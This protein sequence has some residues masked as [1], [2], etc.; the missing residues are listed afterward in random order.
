MSADTEGIAHTV[1]DSP[2]GPLT[3]VATDGVLSGLYMD[4]QRHAPD[5]AG[6]GE[7]RP[8]CLP[9]VSDELTAYFAGDLTTFTVP[10]APRGTAFQHRVWAALRDIRYGQTTTYGELAAMIG[11][12]TAA[13]AVGL[14]NGRN[15]IGIVIPCHRVL[16]FGGALTGYG[17]GLERKRALLAME[18]AALSRS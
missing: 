17:G 9:A 5:P 8:G 10:I 2:L 16:G 4:A 14:A 1:V 7:R 13:R 18:S 6:F 12:P 11:Q 15:P 3:L